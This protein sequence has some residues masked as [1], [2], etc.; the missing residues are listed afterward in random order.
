MTHDIDPQLAIE[1]GRPVRATPLDF[2]PPKI[3]QAEIDAVVATLKSGWLTS[4]PR[5]A[6]LEQRFAEYAESPYA[7]ATSSCTAA[8]HLAMIA[9]DVGAGDEVVTTSFTWPATINAILHAGAQ[10]VFADVDPSTLNIDPAAMER[11]ITD[12][13]SAVLPVHFAG[14]P[15]DMDEIM[16]IARDHGLKVIEDAAHAVEATAGGRKI[17]SIGDFTCFSLYATKSLAGGEGGLITTASEEAAK[18]LRLLR[19]QGISRDPWRRRETPTLGY[20]DVEEP[21]YKANLGDLHAAA[22]LPGLGQV[23]DR[24][25]RRLEIVAR[26]D[27]ALEGLEGITPIGRPDYGQHAHHLYVVRVDA[28]RAG[29]NRDR[30]AEA[31]MAE[32]IATGLHFLPVHTLTWYRKHLPVVELPVAQR[33]GSEVM[34]LPLAAG[35]TDA[36]IDDVIAALL[37]VHAALKRP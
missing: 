8:L 15:C 35:H 21:G 3:G 30:Y 24:R 7:I 33:A 19:S 22:A 16:V 20:Y 26:Y 2:S 6:E 13:T 28:G 17:G 9:A 12:R 23:S 36:D 32:H 34:S 10:P 31:L 25:R 29:A 18:R 27:E 37:K 5:V 4:G 1:G 11:A 14:A